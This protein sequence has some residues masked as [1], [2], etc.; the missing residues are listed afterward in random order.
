MIQ[1][2]E[3]LASLY[4]PNEEVR[5][6]LQSTTPPVSYLGKLAQRVL[7]EPKPYLLSTKLPRALEYCDSDGGCD[8]GGDGCDCDS[9]GCDSE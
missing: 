8:S 2:L 3:A 5:K 7:L 4:R 9:S 1:P 6:E